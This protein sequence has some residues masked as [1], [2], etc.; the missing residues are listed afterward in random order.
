MARR[1]GRVGGAGVGPV[2]GDVAVADEAHGRVQEA[3]VEICRR[4]TA[5]EPRR[6]LVLRVS[7]S[8]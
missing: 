2:E 1:R 8:K 7:G 3:P 5:G 4:S 6:R